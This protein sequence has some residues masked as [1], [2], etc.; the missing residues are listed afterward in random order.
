MNGDLSCSK[1]ALTI[2]NASTRAQATI[3]VD[4]TIKG[5]VSSVKI[6]DRENIANLR[7]F[8]WKISRDD[9]GNTVS[10]GTALPARC[11]RRSAT[12]STPRP[13]RA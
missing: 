4:G 8:A 9:Q 13:L 11:R 7:L 2:R 1:T 6:S 10:C 5:G 3:V 12:S